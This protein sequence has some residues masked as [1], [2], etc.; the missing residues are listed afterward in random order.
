MK[1]YYLIK[2]VTVI[3]TL[4]TVV[5]CNNDSSKTKTANTTTDTPSDPA[6]NI[7]GPI[8]EDINNDPTIVEVNLEAKVSEIEYGCSSFKSTDFFSYSSINLK[9]V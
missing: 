2:L 7:N 8:L 6:N 3:L 4:I 9:F 1:K 5:A